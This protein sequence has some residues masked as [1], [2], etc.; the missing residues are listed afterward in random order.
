MK[1]VLISITLGIIVLVAGFVFII[2]ISDT[3]IPEKWENSNKRGF[4]I[5]L[6]EPGDIL[7]IQ[8]DLS[9]PIAWFG[10]SAMV[11]EDGVLGE[12]PRVGYG[13]FKRDVF[14]WLERN[15]QGKQ[16]SV[17]R[18][19]DMN[20]D[21]NKKLMSNINKHSNKNYT[22]GFKTSENGFYCS[23]FIW[24]LYYKTAL[25]MGYSL[26]IDS[27]AGLF[28]TPYDLLNKDYFNKIEI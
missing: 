3:S 24:F 23:Q 11:M 20:S 12:Y 4:D 6:L 25:D 8:K 1:N 10:H 13:F 16:F 18:F 19:K 26:D 17:L 21:F 9:N 22:I 7:I 5:K 14:N 27:N 28:V 2:L 15:T